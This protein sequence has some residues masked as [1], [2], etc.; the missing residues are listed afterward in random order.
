[1]M[2]RWI[3]SFCCFTVLTSSNG[4]LVTKKC[5]KSPT[6]HV[7]DVQL[8][9]S[10]EDGYY[11]GEE[12]GGG[13]T[14]SASN[15]PRGARPRMRPIRPVTI[16]KKVEKQRQE[17]QARHMEA[18]KD[19]TLLTNVKFSESEALHPAT[20]RGLTDA[21]GL[22]VMTEI[23]AKSLAAALDGKSI[24]GSARTGTGKTLAFLIPI[25]ERLLETDLSLYRPGHNIGAIIVAPTRELAIQIADQAEALLTFHKGMTVSCIYGGTKIQRDYRYLSGASLPSILVATPGRLL[26]H[27]ENTRINRRKFCDIAEETKIIVLDETDRLFEAFSK[28]T[29]RILSF[30]P[31]TEKRQTLLYSATI[32][33]KLRGFLKGTMKI[34]FTEIDCVTSTD[35]STPHLNYRVSQTYHVISD[36]DRYVSTLVSI[37]SKEMDDDPENHKIIVFF[38]ASKL[39][40][41]FTKF[42]QIGLR[43]P[44]L[45]IHSRMSQASRSKASNSFRSARRSILFTSDV[46]ARGTNKQGQNETL[47]WLNYFCLFIAIYTRLRSYPYL[48]CEPCCMMTGV[49]YPEVSLVVQVSGGLSFI[50]WEKPLFEAILT[51]LSLLSVR[52][53]NNREW[54]RP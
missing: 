41:F 26:E 33:N 8:Y 45:E 14:L 11:D 5:P 12:G 30:L 37:V 24:L 39:V 28:E 18:L 53:A 4:F 43:I 46:S 25:V 6:L 7:R 50:V 48:C 36:M 15:H 10:M 19:P 35:S 52:G 42:F 9:Q 17:T 34:E 3:A 54:I 20:K 44:V 27:L 13:G 40:R 16:S 21:M 51:F 23:Q 1:M 2:S 31:R 29:K 47:V 32:P 49:D 22:Q 38:P